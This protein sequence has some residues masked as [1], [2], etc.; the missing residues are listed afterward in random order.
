VGVHA[1]LAAALLLGTA[2]CQ[3]G[4][5]DPVEAG[6]RMQFEIRRAIIE[7]KSLGRFGLFALFQ[8]ELAD[9]PCKVPI[10]ES[11]RHCD[12]VVVGRGEIRLT[13]AEGELARSEQLPPDPVVAVEYPADCANQGFDFKTFDNVLPREGPTKDGV[14]VWKGKR[15]QVTHWRLPASR[16]ERCRVVVQATPAF[17]ESIR[18]GPLAR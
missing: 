7:T 4:G 16:G 18:Q 12:V 2:G 15:I 3:R 1:L 5:V 11:N 9:K 6:R 10:S 14:S 8:E 13:V 17:L